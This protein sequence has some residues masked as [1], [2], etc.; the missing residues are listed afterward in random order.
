[1]QEIGI[2]TTRFTKVEAS[3][4]VTVGGAPI[5]YNINR[6]SDGLILADLSFQSQP[7]HKGVNGCFM[8]DL[9]AICI[10]RLRAFQGG[11]FACREYALAITKLEEAAHWLNART[12]DRQRR[13]VEGAYKK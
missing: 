12:E 11:E 9:I 5:V 2:G 3:E 1:M 6:A 7:A 4:G 8:E 13:G 10:H